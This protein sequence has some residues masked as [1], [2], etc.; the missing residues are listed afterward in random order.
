[1][2]NKILI[3]SAI[4]WLVAGVLK[5]IVEIRVNHSFD[6]KRIIGAGGMP[7]S[8]TATVVA[9]MVTTSYIQG[10]NSAEFAIS[11][12]F[13]IVVIHDAVGVRYET[14]EQAK[15]INKIL[16]NPIFATSDEEF[17]RRLK[18]YVGHTPFQVVVGA[19]VGLIVSIIGIMVIK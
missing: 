6:L 10:M 2:Q 13:A 1:M 8:H 18:E 11:F 3:I 16:E 12:I 19:M 4:S 17:E 14:G 5:V 15:V 9:L 7:S